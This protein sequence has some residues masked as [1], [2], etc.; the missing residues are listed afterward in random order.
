MASFDMFKSGMFSSDPLNPH[1]VD[2]QALAEID[3]E[4]LGRRMQH[5]EQNPLA[6]LEGRSQMLQ[7][8][9]QALYNK[10]Y[11][12]ATKNR[13]GHMLGMFA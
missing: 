13:P 3:L 8:L 6:G 2:A 4:E 5:S 10:H 1:Q 11:F 12:K 7:R 9:S